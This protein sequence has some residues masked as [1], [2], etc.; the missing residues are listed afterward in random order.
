M[1]ENRYRF[2]EIIGQIRELL[3]EA[4]DLVPESNRARAESYWYPHIVTSLDN[5]H[6]FMGGSMCCMNDTLEE[7]DESDED[8][9]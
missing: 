4:I 7:W 3:E 1:S 8:E 9:D 5:D 2:E 6:E